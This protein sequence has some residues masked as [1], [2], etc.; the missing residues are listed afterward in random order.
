M[1]VR[2]FLGEEQQCLIEEICT[3]N[4]QQFWV[5]HN[6]HYIKCIIPYNAQDK[7]EENTFYT[8]TVEKVLENNILLM[9][10]KIPC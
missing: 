8:G 2:Q 3:I 9:K 1:Y 6:V 5:G 4:N 7:H 10:P